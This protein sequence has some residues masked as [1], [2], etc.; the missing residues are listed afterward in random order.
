MRGTTCSACSIISR[1]DPGRFGKEKWI[2]ILRMIIEVD[3]TILAELEVLREIP[4][5]SVGLQLAIINQSPR[6]EELWKFRQLLYW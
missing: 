1:P 6:L 2:L 4:G 3:Q 5:A